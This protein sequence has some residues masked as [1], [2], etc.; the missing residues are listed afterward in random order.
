VLLGG[1]GQVTITSTNRQRIVLSASYPSSTTTWTVTGVVITSL[2]TGVT[3][4][5]T[6]Y[7]LCSQ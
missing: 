7:A 1:G 4:R 3:A 2:G 6:A 5:A